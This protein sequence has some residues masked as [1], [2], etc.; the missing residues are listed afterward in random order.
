MSEF[1]SIVGGIE[2]E[3]VFSPYV[4][5]DHVRAAKILEEVEE[6]VKADSFP[7][8]PEGRMRLDEL[9]NS[10][11]KIYTRIQTG[12]INGSYP[13]GILYPVPGIPEEGVGYFSYA[14]ENGKRVDKVGHFTL[15]DTDERVP[16]D[17]VAQLQSSFANED[18]SDKPREAESDSSTAVLDFS[19]YSSG[20]EAVEVFF[21][22]PYPII[23]VLDTH[24]VDSEEFDLNPDDPLDQK[25]L[26]AIEQARIVS[27]IEA[28][29]PL[30]IQVDLDELLSFKTG[31]KIDGILNK[32]AQTDS[33]NEDTEIK[34]IA[35]AIPDTNNFVGYLYSNANNGYPIALGLIVPE[36]EEEFKEIQWLNGANLNPDNPLVQ[37]FLLAL[38]HARELD[39]LDAQLPEVN[40][41][42][43]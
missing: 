35:L 12:D 11:I 33:I 3:G 28:N 36:V 20:R 40:T 37:K 23:D 43:V 42:E 13:T 15:R 39:M 29:E 14:D 18:L 2:R 19:G 6:T 5:E 32:E 17:F 7:Q 27:D 38:E 9:P 24:S 1:E 31:I 22:A 21:E 34:F 10:G 26:S 16:R 8:T 4:F 30:S 25:L 41:D